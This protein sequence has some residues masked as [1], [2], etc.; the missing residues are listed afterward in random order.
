MMTA[1][2]DDLPERL[3][4]VLSGYSVHIS[5][6]G[7]S[8]THTQTLAATRQLLA[9]ETRMIPIPQEVFKH[10]DTDSN[11]LRFAG[12]AKGSRGSQV[13]L[14][15]NSGSRTRLDSPQ[16]AKRKRPFFTSNTVV[17]RRGVVPIDHGVCR[18]T[19]L[20]RPILSEWASDELTH[21][22]RMRSSVEMNRGS[23]ALMKKTRGMITDDVISV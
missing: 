23:A 7:K 3:R 22:F 21:V 4:R 14:I 6:S 16:R 20:F 13:S 19:S 1:R 10:I 11:E 12:D 2:T 17:R 5:V 8:N 15:V 9:E 18:Q